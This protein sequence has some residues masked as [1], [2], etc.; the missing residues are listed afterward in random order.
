MDFIDFGTVLWMDFIY[1]GTV[2]RACSST[3]QRFRSRWNPWRDIGDRGSNVAQSWISAE[4]FGF[5]GGTSV[6]GIHWKILVTPAEISSCTLKS[7][8]GRRSTLRD[9]SMDFDGTCTV[10]K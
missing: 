10:E 3:F 6:G 5:L 2:E 7:T 1:F 9:P 8:L 4:I